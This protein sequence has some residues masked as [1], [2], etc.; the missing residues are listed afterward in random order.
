MSLP[1]GKL[2]NMQAL[3]PFL[4]PSDQ[5]LVD[6]KLLLKYLTPRRCSF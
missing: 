1:R 5:A 4:Q 3:V 6:L 2:E